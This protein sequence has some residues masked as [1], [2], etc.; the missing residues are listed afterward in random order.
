MASRL[1]LW[2]ALC[3]V[4]YVSAFNL[5]PP[6]DPTALA[7]VL[8]ITTTCLEALNETVP[9]CDDTLFHLAAEVD[10]YWWEDD[11]VAALCSGNCSVAAKYWDLNVAGACDEQYL[12][13]YGKMIPVSSVS[14]RYVDGLN[15]ACLGSTTND[16]WCVVES[17]GWQGSDVYRPDC[18]A[19]PTDPACANNGAD[20][21]SYQRLADLYEDDILCNDC[22]IQML[23]QR[24]TSP[25]LPV[26]NYSD[27]LVDQLQDIG[28]I[29]STTLPNITTRDVPTYQ[30]APTPTVTRNV[31]ATTS[32]TVTPTCLGQMITGSGCDTLSLKFGV[33]TGD[34]QA[35]SRSATCTISGSLCLPAACELQLVTSGSTCESLAQ[36]APGNITLT[37]FFK[38]NPNIIGLCDRPT[39]GQYVC[40]GAPGGSYA[41]AAPPLGSDGDVG[42]QQRGGS[43][44]GS[45]SNSTTS[46]STPSSTQAS[47]TSVAVPGPTQTGIDPACNKY[48]KAPVGGNC[49]DFAS[50][51]GIT[52]AQLYAW[53]TVLGQNGASC[54]TLFWGNEY[55]CVGVAGDSSS[56]ST[57][58]TSP[59]TTSVTAPGPTQSGIV[60]TC[61]SFA[62]PAAQQG[63]YDF[64]QAHGITLAQLCSWNSVLGSDCGNCGSSFWGGT[65]Y[66]VRVSS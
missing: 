11:N 39:V 42:N 38:W 21:P 17:Q 26:S 16:T 34:L 12:P 37:Q 50:D 13:V 53:N 3:V 28:D 44:D 7:K 19:D 45:T 40:I 36:G 41:L 57:T 61:N 24:V 4:P 1:I 10:R 55:Y 66:C 23:Y 65:Y 22:F 5:Y 29:C 25:F 58:T 2:L 46:S 51:N 31:T 64:A 18:E 30:P 48:A 54:S 59:S 60:S 8:N 62:E 6:Y 47:S 27:F 14:G 63:C 32:P 56:G 43:D 9:E 49:I 15:L 33:T 20:V 35:W 52:P